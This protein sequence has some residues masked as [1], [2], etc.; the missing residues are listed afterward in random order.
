[1]ETILPQI[2]FALSVGIF[3]L[4]IFMHAVRQNT[5]LV[6]LYL[7]QSLLLSFLLILFAIERKEQMLFITAFLTILI[8]VS[9]A[10]AFFYRLINKLKAIKEPI[11]PGGKFM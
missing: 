3:L 9:V 7:L 2:I 5:T 11:I 10:P 6:N 4:T 1:M 8:K